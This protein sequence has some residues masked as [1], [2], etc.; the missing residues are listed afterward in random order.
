MKPLLTRQYP[1]TGDLYGYT[2]VTSEDGSTTQKLY[3]TNPSQVSMSLSINLLGDLVIESETKMQI[4]AKLQNIKD[5]NGEQIY[6]N[7]VWEIIQT[8]PLLSG[9]GTKEGYKYRA[10]LISGDV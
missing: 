5:K 4:S 6:L 1:Y 2:I 10:T 8:S 3:A 9:I 7:G